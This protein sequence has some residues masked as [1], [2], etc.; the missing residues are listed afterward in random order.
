[1]DL[2]EEEV[3]RYIAEAEEGRITDISQR[4]GL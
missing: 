3:E 4:F 1:L 2:L